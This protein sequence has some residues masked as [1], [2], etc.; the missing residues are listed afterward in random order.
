MSFHTSVW[1]RP[2]VLDMALFCFSPQ[3]GSERRP[4]LH[5]AG[6][7]NSKIPRDIF[8]DA[9][10]PGSSLPPPPPSASLA[11]SIQTP[12]PHRDAAR[13]LEHRSSS[14]RMY[15]GKCMPWRTLV[16]S[17]YMHGDLAIYVPRSFSTLSGFCIAHLLI[18]H[19]LFSSTR[20][21]SPPPPPST[22]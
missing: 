11:P 12:S 10:L 18:R 5:I 9:R 7:L 16:P 22:V 1:I 2:D 19:D 13:H 15:G 20:Q 14:P 8:A 3:L 17:Y 4:L 21:S 6:E